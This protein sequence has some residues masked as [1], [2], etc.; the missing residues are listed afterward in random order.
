[1]SF[2]LFFRVFSN[3]GEDSFLKTF[4]FNYSCRWSTKNKVGLI[5]FVKTYFKMNFYA[6]YLSS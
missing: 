5:F 3:Q 4:F 6:I 2:V 1:M